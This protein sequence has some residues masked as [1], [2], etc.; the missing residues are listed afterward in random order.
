MII[1]VAVDRNKKPVLSNESIDKLVE[2][3]DKFTG[4]HINEAKR[5]FDQ[6]NL[7]LDGFLGEL[8]RIVTYQCNSNRVGDSINDIEEYWIYNLELNQVID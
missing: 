3:L 8:E 7:N 2:E 6:N 5:F 4:V 1:Y